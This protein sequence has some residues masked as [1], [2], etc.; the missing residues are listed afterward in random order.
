M[1]YS[2]EITKDY[3]PDIALNM[4]VIVAR[5][6]SL[7]GCK[8]ILNLVV[9]LTLH[10]PLYNLFKHKKFFFYLSSFMHKLK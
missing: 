8:S 9:N 4:V 6:T 7:S 5:V 1:L 2:N 10:R 3:F